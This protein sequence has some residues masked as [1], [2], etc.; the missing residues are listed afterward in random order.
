LCEINKGADACGDAGDGNGGGCWVKRHPGGGTLKSADAQ[1]CA[2]LRT[3]LNV[4]GSTIRSRRSCL[5]I[6]EGRR[7]VQ[8][9]LWPK[10]WPKRHP[11]V[12]NKEG[13][14]AMLRTLAHVLKLRRLDYTESREVPVNLLRP[15]HTAAMWRQALLSLVAVFVKGMIEHNTC[16]HK[17]KR[18]KREVSREGRGETSRRCLLLIHEN[19]VLVWGC[20]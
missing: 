16:E 12:N 11:G 4:V 3:S 10:Q 20:N 17:R 2:R 13:G 19:H 6:C 9:C 14:R 15:R 7:H 1:Y 18:A 8:Q 5:C